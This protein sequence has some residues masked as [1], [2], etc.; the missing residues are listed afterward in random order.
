MKI[1]GL[2]LEKAGKVVGRES[3][4]AG[5]GEVEG[6]QSWEWCSF[7]RHIASPTLP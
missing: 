6:S 5:R 2:G 1:L 7:D 4:V 3:E